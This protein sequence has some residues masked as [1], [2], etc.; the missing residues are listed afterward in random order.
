MVDGAASPTVEEG[1]PI[2]LLIRTIGL[3]LYPKRPLQRLK[4]THRRTVSLTGRLTPPV[5]ILEVVEAVSL[6]TEE[7]E[8]SCLI[9]I[10]AEEA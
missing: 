2:L 1:T 8:V 10:V 7:E 3:I 6:G 4:H 9:S 5:G